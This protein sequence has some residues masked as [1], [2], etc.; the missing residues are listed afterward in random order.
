MGVSAA[1]KS[2]GGSAHRTGPL[3]YSMDLRTKPLGY[4]LGGKLGVVMECPE[5]GES[6]A[7]LRAGVDGGKPYREYAHHIGIWLD[8]KHE[9]QVEYSGLCRH[10]TN[11]RH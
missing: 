8:S 4:G 3:E 7:F 6:C 5:C 9:P 2:K 1:S 10:F 11:R